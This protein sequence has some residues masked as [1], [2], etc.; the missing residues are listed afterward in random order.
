MSCRHM[1]AYMKATTKEISLYGLSNMLI[2]TF[3]F[4]Y[5]WV[6]ASGYMH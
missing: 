5:L 2:R 6:L 1:A 3:Y 4:C